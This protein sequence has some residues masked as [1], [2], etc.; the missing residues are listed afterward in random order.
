M[1]NIANVLYNSLCY[2]VLNYYLETTAD[3]LLNILQYEY[4]ASQPTPTFLILKK[5]NNENNLFQVDLF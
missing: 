4:P 1:A 3:S 5:L 2:L